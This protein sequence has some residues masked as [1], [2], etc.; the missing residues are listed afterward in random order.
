MAEIVNLR[1]FR[2]QKARADREQAAG[3]NRTLHGRTKA[4]RQRDRMVADKSERFV[5][6]HHREKPGE[7]GDPSDGQ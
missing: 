3:Q 7:P 6:G 5:A 4:E 1:Q 2:K